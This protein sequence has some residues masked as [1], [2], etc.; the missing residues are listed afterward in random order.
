MRGSGFGLVSADVRQAAPRRPRLPRSGRAAG[1]VASQLPSRNPSRAAAGMLIGNGAIAGRRPASP[2]DRRVTAATGFARSTI[3]DQRVDRLGRAPSTHGQAERDRVAEEDLRERLADD[4][5]DPAAADRLRRVLARR[6]AAE[7]RVDDAGSPR[8]RSAGSENGCGS[9]P[10]AS[11]CARSSSNRCSSRPS[12]EIDLQE[13][14]RDD[15][16]GVDVVAGQRQRRAADLADLLNGHWSSP[17][18]ST[19][20]PAI[21]AAATI[22][23]LISSVRPVGL[24]C[25]PL[26]L[27]FDDE[28]Q[29]SRP[30]S[31][32]WF[33]AR[34]IEQP[35]PR[36]SNPASVNTRSSPSRSAAARTP[37]DPGTTSALTCGATW[38]AADDPRGF[39]QVRQPGVRARSD[40][41]DVDARA[42]DRIAAVKAH[43]VERLGERR[44]RRRLDVC[45]PRQALVDV[46]RLPG[47]DAPRHRR[48]DRRRV[49]L[50]RRRRS[51]R[52]DRRPCSRHH[53]TARSKA[54][55]CGANRRPRR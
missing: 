46:D 14:R 33:I 27:R 19:T 5:A 28:A 22:A 26:K 36:H 32:S 16:I 40:E 25:R 51:A 12:N 10:C 20:S 1:P 38:L 23:G 4:G 31:R 24:P 35:A 48:P 44:A 42:L 37:C 55:P 34:H 13:A 29:T 8:R 11:I 21:A 54:S 39:A 6:A 30:S 2:P 3:C 49:D 50:D 17:C 53:A 9:P 43:E 15:A 45:R 47:I 41:R 18:T 52:P 7:I